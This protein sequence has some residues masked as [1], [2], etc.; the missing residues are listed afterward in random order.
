MKKLIAIGTAILALM[1]AGHGGVQQ[2]SPDNPPQRPKHQ[3]QQL[4]EDFEIA[5]HALEEGHSG[6]YRY[7]PK[8]KMDATFDAAERSLDHPMD[9]YEF[10][11]VVAPAVNAIKCG[12]TGLSLPDAVRQELV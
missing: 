5:R 10:V 6:I 8:V 3:P 1:I 7:T 2:A 4:R 11:R 12:H 9:V